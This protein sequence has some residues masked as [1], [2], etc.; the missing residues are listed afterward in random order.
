VGKPDRYLVD[1][2]SGVGWSQL[3]GRTF[4]RVRGILDLQCLAGRCT[5]M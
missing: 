5:D 1:L 3:N 4:K 2:V